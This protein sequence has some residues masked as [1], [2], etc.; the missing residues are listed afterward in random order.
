MNWLSYFLVIGI[1]TLKFMFGPLS[2]LAAGLSWFESFVCTVLGMMLTTVSL[3]QL[4]NF[5]KRVEAYFLNG[6]PKKSPFNRRNRWAIKVRQRLGMWGVALLTPIVFT[7]PIGVILALAFRYSKQ[8]IIFKM[9]VSAIIWGLLQVFFF[10][11]L[12]DILG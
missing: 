5:L 9:L 6:K 10:Y 1:S 3:I 4:S 8:E 12:R 11:Y 2:G 7:P